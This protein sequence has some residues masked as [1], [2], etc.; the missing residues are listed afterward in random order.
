[1]GALRQLAAVAAAVREAGWL[2][3]FLPNFIFS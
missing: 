1:M 2:P 3:I